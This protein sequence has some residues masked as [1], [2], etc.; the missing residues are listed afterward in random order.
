MKD[1]ISG[2]VVGL[3]TL[4]ELGCI[5]ELARIALRRNN[6][7]YKAECKLIER[8]ADLSFATI[9]ILKKET[10]I[11]QLKDELKKLKGES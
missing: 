3:A 6:D 4:V 9:D 2:V 11:K 8:E 5:V 10:E 1:K 7:C